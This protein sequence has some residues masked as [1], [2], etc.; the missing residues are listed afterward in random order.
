MV[1]GITALDPNQ[2]IRVTT[3]TEV[4][5]KHGPG[6]KT[7]NPFVSNIERFEKIVLDAEGYLIITHF[8]P[9]D[10]GD[11]VEHIP[12][13]CIFERDDKDPLAK[14][15][16]I[17]KKIE[18][19][20]TEYVICT[21]PKT[22]KRRIEKGPQLYMPKPY[23]QLS[24]KQTMITL[25]VNQYML[26]TDDNTGHIE[27]KNGPANIALEPFEKAG[28]IVEK[29]DLSSTQY[30]VITDT[31]TG[32]MSIQKGPLQYVP[33]PYDQVSK[34]KDMITLSNTQYVYIND[35][36]TGEW[37][38]VK[39][40][41]TFHLE[42]FEVESKIQNV[43]CLNMLQWAKVIDQNTGAIR[44]EKG[45]CVIFLG[46]YEKLIADNG[47]EIQDAITVDVNHAV[48]T[49]NTETG[50][51]SL[52]VKPQKYVPEAPNIQIVEV[53]ELIK[54]AP[55]ESMILFDREGKLSFKSGEKNVEGFF[56]PPFCSVMF[57]LWSTDPDRKIKGNTKVSKFDHRPHDMN[58]KFS[59]R[60]GDN[61]EINIV[62]N[63]YWNIVDLE[64]MIK[65]TSDPPEDICN[66]V[67]NQILNFASSMSTKE[68]MEYSV[69]EIVKKIYDVDSEF[70]KSRGVHVS[71]V[72]ILEKRC[73]SDE[74]ERTYRSI[75]DQ[76]INS[77]R[78][79][80]QQ[81]GTNQTEIARI[82]GL[83]LIEKENYALLQQKLANLELETETAGRAEGGKIKSFLDG[84]GDMPIEDK[85][86]IFLQLERT[87]RIGLVTDKVQTVYLNPTDADFNLNVVRLEETKKDK[88]TTKDT[89]LVD[90][91]KEPKEIKSK[92]ATISLN[93]DPNKK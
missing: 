81:M 1:F 56:I 91:D 11:I 89:N 80:E 49:R 59:V 70:Y 85:I 86:N 53:K 17:Q 24:P 60:S 78:S 76:K 90:A 34:I 30:L 64:K 5:I 65:T 92:K 62:V 57:Q 48:H 69:A 16:A 55:F 43:T 25:T 20:S 10:H 82:K 54:L 41:K 88:T 22:G 52:V 77:A 18:L 29:I 93:L 61:V 31:K 3:P 42:P 58:F 35:K 7:Y 50:E 26:V 75:I 72:Q 2:S 23:E 66:H 67:K 15:S 9:R 45:P 19:G 71:R 39:G 74:I 14:V 79:Y 38:I 51:E 36:A 40:P 37:K 83:T 63:V 44:I 68:F 13:P 12:G 73:A 28:K 6:W 8:K 46:P 33:G 21:D 4:Y 27:C 32:H 84:L 87:K 47:K